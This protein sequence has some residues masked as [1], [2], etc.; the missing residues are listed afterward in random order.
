MPVAH[1]IAVLGLHAG[2]GYLLIALLVALDAVL[3]IVPAEAAVLGGAA[4]VA[5][6]QL[7]LWPLLAATAVGAFAGDLA[8]YRA[9]RLVGPPVLRRLARPRTRAALDRALGWLTRRGAVVLIA[10]RFVP[11]GRTASTLAAGLLGLPA[12]LVA[13]CAAIGAVLWSGYLIALGYAGS[14]LLPVP[15]YALAPA[16]ALAVFGAASLAGAGWRFRP[17]GRGPSRRT[18]VSGPRSQPAPRPGAAPVPGRR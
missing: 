2:G 15:P 4:L 3:P 11:G 14:R 12:R 1:Q 13:G 7:E 18:T 8:S 6:G 16:L 5:R 10:A 17:G 9:G